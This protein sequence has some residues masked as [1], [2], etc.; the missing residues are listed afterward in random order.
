MSEDTEN[1]HDIEGNLCTL[2]ALCRKEPEWA[3]GRIREMRRKY[4]AIRGVLAAADEVCNEAMQM[5][6]SVP[7]KM[8]EQVKRVRFSVGCFRSI[9]SKHMRSLVGA[10]EAGYRGGPERLERVERALANYCVPRMMARAG[11]E[12][13]FKV[14]SRLI[15]DAVDE[16]GQG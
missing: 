1:Y 2:E 3:A 13:D 8:T 9:C 7:E 6:V 15:V 4:A 10:G 5:T 12:W 16:G 11:Q 14:L